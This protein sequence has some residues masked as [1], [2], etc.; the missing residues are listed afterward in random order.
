[1]AGETLHSDF[2]KTF[3]FLYVD[4]QLF[5]VGMADPS[6]KGKMV[7]PPQPSNKRMRQQDEVGPLV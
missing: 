5:V 1:M 3:D 6:G 7:V 4:L 2:A